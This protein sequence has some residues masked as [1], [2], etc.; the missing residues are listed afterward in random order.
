M[1]FQSLLLK[2]C[3]SKEVKY[4]YYSEPCQCNVSDFFLQDYRHVIIGFTRLVEKL[5]CQ[6]L[7]SLLISKFALIK[8]IH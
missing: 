1:Y 6:V 7:H 3:Y 2:H 8:F 4:K 5:P